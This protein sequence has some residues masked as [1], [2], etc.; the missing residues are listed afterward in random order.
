MKSSKSGQGTTTE[1]YTIARR[2][3]VKTVALGGAATAI[4]KMVP[5]QWTRPVIESVLLPAHA[6]T[7]GCV[8][9]S[10]SVTVDETGDSGA[11]SLGTFNSSGTVSGSGASDGSGTTLNFSIAAQVDPSVASMTL[12]MNFQSDTDPFGRDGAN[13]PPPQ[14]N[15]P[16]PTGILSFSQTASSFNNNLSDGPTVPSVFSFTLDGACG[17]A[18]ITIVLEIPV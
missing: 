16:D 3:L 18:P 11:G 14:T 12:G 1:K 5:D 9:Q 17:G 4:T 6:Q 10:F 7:T 13:V 15:A 8:I 2:K